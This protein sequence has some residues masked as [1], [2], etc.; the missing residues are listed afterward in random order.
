VSEA[1]RR[2]AASL[3]LL[4]GGASGALAYGLVRAFVYLRGGGGA[5][6]LVLRQQTIAY[7]QVLGVAAFVGL[8]A[9]LGAYALLARAP[10]QVEVFERWLGRVVLPSFLA[11]A[12]LDV[13]CP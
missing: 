7:H 9:G 6:A 2:V 5:L 13:L 3:S 11:A 1:P 4:A 10:S 8:S 12:V